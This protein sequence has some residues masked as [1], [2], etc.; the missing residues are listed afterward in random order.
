MSKFINKT[1][2][3][4]GANNDQYNVL[5]D[6][7][8][9]YYFTANAGDADDLYTAVQDLR[10]AT[11]QFAVVATNNAHQVALLKQANTI[12]AQH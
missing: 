2:R 10:V 6:T 9:T 5:Q 8:S 4:T 7:V 1:A 11:A 3:T 12:L